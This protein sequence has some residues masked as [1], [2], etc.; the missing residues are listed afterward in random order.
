MENQGD[1][2]P[3]QSELIIGKRRKG[4]G[5]RSG[6]PFLDQAA[7]KMK[8]AVD[9]CDDDTGCKDRFG[10]DVEMNKPV[11]D[12]G[13]ENDDRQMDPPQQDPP[14]LFRDRLLRSRLFYKGP[15]SAKHVISLRCDLSMFLEHVL[16]F[17]KQ[18]FDTDGLLHK[19]V[20]G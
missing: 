14:S 16:N 11:A 19:L 10:R 7:G 6:V 20:H 17:F 9:Q 8:H 5:L 1:K 13:N 3:I 4:S 2:N 15:D 18:D 12:E